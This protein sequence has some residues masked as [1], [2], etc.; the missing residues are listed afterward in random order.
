MKI[1]GNLAQHVMKKALSCFSSVH[2]PVSFSVCRAL[3]TT[4]CQLLSKVKPSH[5]LGRGWPSSDHPLWLGFSYSCHIPAETWKKNYTE[6]LACG[7][8]RNLHSI[9]SRY[10]LSSFLVIQ[11]S[12]SSKYNFSGLLLVSYTFKDLSQNHYLI[13]KWI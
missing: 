11:F 3:S 8:I 2:I 6:H 4:S 1:Y 12:I 9:T 7:D 5:S 10:F 13:Y